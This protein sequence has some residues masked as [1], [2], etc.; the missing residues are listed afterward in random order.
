MPWL[1]ERWPALRAL[2]YRSLVAAPTPVERLAAVSRSSGAEL[3]CKRDDLTHPRYGGNKVRKLE[4]LLA[5]A[6]ACGAGAIVTTGAWG[7]H[8]V[9]ATAVHGAEAGFEVH[10]VLV[11][12]PLDEHV[13][14]QLRADLRAGARL[15]PVPAWALV[16]AAMRLVAARLRIAGV[17]PYL[18][19]PGGSS[20]VGCIGYV[21]AGLELAEQIAARALPEP[22]TITVALGSGATAVGLALGLAAAGLT[23]PVR[24]VRVTSRLV[25]SRRLLVRLARRTVEVLRRAD[26]RFPDVARVAMRR[27]QV[28]HRQFAPG[29][30]RSTEA[31]REAMRVARDDGLVLDPTYTSKAFAS[32]LALVRGGARGPHLF[33]HTLSSAPMEPLLEGAPPLPAWAR[34][35]RGED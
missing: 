6:R 9:L 17:R 23:V 31:S 19:G 21:E 3:W 5:D 28:D 34:R 33:W 24:A 14:A 8:H 27:L 32:L 26:D 16:P 35:V 15:L 7:S 29:Y 1:F 2:P 4:W 25:V 20:P 22:A 30:G 18:L 10:A 11:P 13:E 12:Q